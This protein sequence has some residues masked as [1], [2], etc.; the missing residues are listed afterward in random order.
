MRLNTSHVLTRR[1]FAGQ[2]MLVLAMTTGDIH[3]AQTRYG[4]AVVVNR[5]G[6]AHAYLIEGPMHEGRRR[7]VDL[8]ENSSVGETARISTGRDGRLCLALSPGAVICVAPGTDLT[9]QQLRM[10][11][12]G[13]PPREEDLVRRVY[14][15]VS[16]GRVMVHAGAPVPSMDTRVR[17]GDGEVRAGGGTFAVA[18]QQDGSWAVFNDAFDQDII[19]EN[20]TPLA[21]KGNAVAVMQR[22]ADG[23]AEARLVDSLADSP[24]RKFEVCEVFFKDLEPF[25]EDPVRFDRQGLSTYIGGAGG[26][27]KFVGGDITAV[28]V[29]PS[30]RPVPVANVQ[31]RVDA[32]GQSGDRRWGTQRIWDWYARIG[33]VKGFNYVPRYAVNS[34]EMWMEN[35]FNPD[36]IGQELGWARN[37]GYTAVRVQLQ[38][39]VWRHDADG[40]LER[41][42]KFLELAQ[43]NGM[44]VVPIL[45]D[46]LNLA[47]VEPVVGPQPD[48]SPDT[49]NSRWTPS[50]GP[51]KVADRAAWGELESYVDA[52]VKKFRRDDRVLFWDLYNMA[53]AGSMGE[54]SLPLMDQTFNWARN[55]DPEQP[56]AVAAWTRFGSAMTTHKLE[57]SDLVTFQSFDAPQQT[58]ALLTLLQRYE[59]PVICTDWLLRQNG[60]DFESMLP[61]FAVHRVGWFNRGL[62]NGRTQTWLQQTQFRSEQNPD[63]WQHD[64]FL[65]NGEP[66]SLQEVEHIKAFRFMETPQ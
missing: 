29:S 6:D 47:G 61:L 1:V 7:R 18:R 44:R 39:E 42:D 35:T 28:D 54:T 9:L 20:G 59:R 51:S 38:S 66:Y 41:L 21:L 27:V 57:R 11:A 25:L 19:P 63:L 33:P 3:A 32:G 10:A 36:I 4:E 64:V 56:L 49:H 43:R 31:P 17:T 2:F 30:F 13:L 58:E 12:D 62:V 65:D 14:I 5:V 16:K 53:G 37:A 22:G 34:T 46:D 8:V 50:P 45:F 15:N 23:A 26:S 48:P 24:L 40:F 52:V 55:A 60:N